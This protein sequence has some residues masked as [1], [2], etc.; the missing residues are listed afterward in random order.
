MASWVSEYCM[1]LGYLQLMS[2]LHSVRRYCSEDSAMT[3]KRWSYNFILFSCNLPLGL[4]SAA[5][6]PYLTRCLTGAGHNSNSN[7]N[8]TTFESLNLLTGMSLMQGTPT[9]FTCIRRPAKLNPLASFFPQPCIPLSQPCL[10]CLQRFS[11]DLCC[12]GQ[13]WTRTGIIFALPCPETVK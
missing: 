9:T 8:S 2:T 1:E 13:T 10:P 11:P 12:G 6:R 7:F 5:R 3:R 4:G